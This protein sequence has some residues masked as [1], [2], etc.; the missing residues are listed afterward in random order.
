MSQPAGVEKMNDTISLDC[1][2]LHTAF[3]QWQADEDSLDAEWNESIAAL[4]AYQAHLDAWQQDLAKARADLAH[5]RERWN[6]ERTA[7]EQDREESAVKLAGQLDEA[8]E[9]ATLASQQLSS[10]AEE[11]RQLDQRRAD[12]EAELKLAQERAKQLAAELESQRHILDHERAA[13]AD[14]LQHMQSLLEQKCEELAVLE[15]P[16]TVVASASKNTNT[17]DGAPPRGSGGNVGERRSS[18]SP[19]LGSIVEQFGKLRQQRAFDRQLGK[20]TR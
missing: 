5:E 4:S 20:K 13:W 19:V 2:P 3:C 12:V 11:L 8:R 9:K 15:H 1:E 17:P 10:R 16:Q 6:Q 14:Q 18:N 7:A